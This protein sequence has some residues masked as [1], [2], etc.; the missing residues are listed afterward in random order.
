[1]TPTPV[2]DTTSA[3]VLGVPTE[4]LAR[5]GLRCH[6]VMPLVISAPSELDTAKMPATLPTICT[7]GWTCP[8]ECP[9]VAAAEYQP[10]SRSVPLEVADRLL[11]RLSA[12]SSSQSSRKA[13]LPSLLVVLV[14]PCGNRWCASSRC[15]ESFPSTSSAVPKRPVPSVHDKNS[16]PEPLRQ[17]FGPWMSASLATE[18]EMMQARLRRFA[19]RSVSRRRGGSR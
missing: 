2:F 13:A 9:S 3:G 15:A 19:S 16:T 8:F 12:T 14:S 18:P 5:I 6:P 11:T 10:G 1:M 4:L 17:P 7:N